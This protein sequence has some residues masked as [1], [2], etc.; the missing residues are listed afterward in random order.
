MSDGFQHL[1][2]A[3][4]VLVMTSNP[5]RISS[6]AIGRSL[7]HWYI[8]YEDHFCLVEGCPLRLPIEWRKQGIRVRQQL[9]QAKDQQPSE[10]DRLDY[11]HAKFQMF[12]LQCKS[13]LSQ[14]SQ[15][16]NLN[17]MELPAALVYMENNIQQFEQKMQEFINSQQVLDIMQCASPP[18]PLRDRLIISPR[19]PFPGYRFQFPEVG[20]LLIEYFSCQCLTHLSLGTALNG[21]KSAT[22]E[23]SKHYLAAMHC[24]VEISKTFF[25]LDDSLGDNPDRMLPCSEALF[26]AS[27]SVP[28]E[29]WWQ[30][31]MSCKLGHLE[32]SGY[33]LQRKCKEMLAARW[34][35]PDI[36][37][38]RL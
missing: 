30:S 23:R 33:K 4:N 2:G 34:N 36:A 3:S 12:T 37:V 26:M 11:L 7:L 6:T 28:N 18:I 5:G 14:M 13:L 17:E 15:L 25:G 21:V 31:W 32:R 9:A 8:D 20:F 19:L 29:Q 22:L 1:K 35:M 38:D 10:R 24:S 27:L 16:R